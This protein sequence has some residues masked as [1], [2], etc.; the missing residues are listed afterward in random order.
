[1]RDLAKMK[2]SGQKLEGGHLQINGE[3]PP[4]S[5]CSKKLNAFAKRHQCS[6]QYVDSSGQKQNY[7]RPGVL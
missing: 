6:I 2:R 3:L 7:P 4:C 1:M 5:A